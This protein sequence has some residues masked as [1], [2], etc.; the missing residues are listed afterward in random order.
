V[1]NPLQRLLSIEHTIAS[2]LAVPSSSRWR[3][4]VAAGAHIGDGLLWAVIGLALAIWGGSYC[5]RVAVIAALAV[6]LDGALST[7]IKYAI[8]RQRPQDLAHFYAL[9][10]DRYSFPSGH[11]PRMTAIATVFT[12]SLPCLAPASYGLALLVS[13]CRVSVG[14]HYPSDVFTGLAIGS[15]GAACILWIL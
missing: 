10:S 14:V 6:L 7:A 11:A 12:W 2:S 4:L 13:L 9:N 15:L 1:S 3:W 8:R 5:R